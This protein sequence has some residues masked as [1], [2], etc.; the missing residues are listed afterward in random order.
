MGGF[1]YPGGRVGWAESDR[2]AELRQ[3]FGGTPPQHGRQ[4]GGV[5]EVDLCD[6]RALGYDCRRGET[7]LFYDHVDL[8]TIHCD[9]CRIK[10]IPINCSRNCADCSINGSE[11][12][13]PKR[14][15]ALTTS[16]YP[17]FTSNLAFGST[18]LS[19]SDVQFQVPFSLRVKHTFA[20]TSRSKQPLSD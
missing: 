17:W 1:F 20:F 11:R 16:R 8:F 14:L 6:V 10:R 18:T 13:R 5:P 2:S 9:C 7:P 15:S 4:R 3:V 12:E 19:A